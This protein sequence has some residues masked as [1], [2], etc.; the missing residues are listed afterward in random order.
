MTTIAFDR[1]KLARALQDDAKLSSDQAESI[2][3]IVF[4]AQ[5]TD[6]ATRADVA[7]SE[8]ILISEIRAQFAG[9]RLDLIQTL[10]GAIALQT[11]ILLGAIWLVASILKP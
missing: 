7:A 4:R 3:E 5:R 9:M 11:V 6:L 2:A 10:L 1:P 8:T